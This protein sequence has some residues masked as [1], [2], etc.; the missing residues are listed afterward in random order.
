MFHASDILTPYG[1]TPTFASVS[2]QK[3]YISFFNTIDPNKGIQGL[4]QWLK[5]SA[6]KQ[7][8]NSKALSND[9]LADDFRVNSYLLNVPN[10]TRKTLT[11][12]LAS[13]PCGNIK[14]S[15]YVSVRNYLICKLF[16]NGFGSFSL[17]FSY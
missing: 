9:L 2:I 7:L 3:Y 12:D 5:W 11:R 14:I 1:I 13:G 4:P 15:L 17:S 16:S 6:G 8:L 10:L